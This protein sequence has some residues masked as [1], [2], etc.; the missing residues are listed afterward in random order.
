MDLAVEIN[1]DVALRLQFILVQCVH[2]TQAQKCITTVFLKLCPTQYLYYFDTT[3]IML[4]SRKSS[5]R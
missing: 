1:G 2:V 4:I 5:V 3:M